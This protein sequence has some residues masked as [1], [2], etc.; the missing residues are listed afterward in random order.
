MAALNLGYAVIYFLVSEIYLYRWSTKDIE[1]F[2]SEDISNSDVSGEGSVG[3]PEGAASNLEFIDDD[4]APLL[5][6]AARKPPG[7]LVISTSILN[8]PECSP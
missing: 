8:T 4:E 7:E 1:N 5:D 6:P 2:D 3:K